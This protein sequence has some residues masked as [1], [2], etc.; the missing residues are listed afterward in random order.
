MVS[1]ARAI[2]IGTSAIVRRMRKW[3]RRLCIRGKGYGSAAAERLSPDG[4]TRLARSAHLRSVLCL[5]FVHPT[6]GDYNGV[7]LHSGLI[8]RHPRCSVDADR[9]EEHT[10][11]LQSLAY[12]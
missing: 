9:S 12:L 5:S 8:Q 2:E 3:R 10:S 4:D 7:A 1:C 11:E 6:A